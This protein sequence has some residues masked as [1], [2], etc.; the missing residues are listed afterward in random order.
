[1]AVDSEQ[2][3]ILKRVH[4]NAQGDRV[5][6]AELAT[7]PPLVLRRVVNERALELKEGESAYRTRCEA[8]SKPGYLVRTNFQGRMM[9]GVGLQLFAAFPAA[10]VVAA[11]AQLL[12]APVVAPAHAPAPVP[13][14]APIPAHTHA[15][16]PVEE[17]VPNAAP[18]GEGV[19]LIGA[20]EPL[21]EPMDADVLNALM[22]VPIATC[23]T[24]VLLCQQSTMW[25]GLVLIPR[26]APRSR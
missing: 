7:L 24:V 6:D 15:H 16:V 26:C 3:A 19:P 9:C 8:A 14:P 21:E 25:R 12:R 20:Q 4:A 22:P 11:A 1:M 18:A 5:S 13:I 10:Q 17:A 23:F 2:L